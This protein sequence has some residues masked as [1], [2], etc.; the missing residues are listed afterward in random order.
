MG[1]KE[2]LHG[3]DLSMVYVGDLQKNTDEYHGY[4]M[5]DADHMKRILQAVPVTPSKSAFLDVGCGRVD[6]QLA[7]CA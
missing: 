7:V 6:S 5:T 3:L 2:R 1:S 4:S